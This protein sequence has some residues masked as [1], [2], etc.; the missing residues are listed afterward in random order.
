MNRGYHALANIRDCFRFVA[1]CNVADLRAGGARADE[2]IANIN[3]RHGP[4]TTVPTRNNAVY[5]ISIFDTMA[6]DAIESDLHQKEEQKERL[7]QSVRNIEDWI[8][9]NRLTESPAEIK[10]AEFDIAEYNDRIERVTA[11]IAKLNNQR[12]NFWKNRIATQEK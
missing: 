5:Q 12:N 3:M 1:E 2:I 10:E 8:M 6:Y 4:R 11:E 9:V 7:H